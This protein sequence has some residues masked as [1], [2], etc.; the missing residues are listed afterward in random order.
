MAL[1]FSGSFRGL[2]M[3]PSVLLLRILRSTMLRRRS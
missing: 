2:C 3:F 1:I